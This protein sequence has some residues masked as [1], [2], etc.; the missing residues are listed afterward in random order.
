MDEPAPMTQP[1]ISRNGLATLDLSE[2]ESGGSLPSVAPGEVLREEFMTPLGLSARALAR[3][4]AVPANRITA[5]LR[6][7]RAITA[8]TALLLG[9]RFGTSAEFWMNLQ[10][11][12]DLEVARRAFGLAA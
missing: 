5:I 11:M 12:H 1:L 8:E 9:R 4:M 7:T 10:V 6:G 2:V 3:D